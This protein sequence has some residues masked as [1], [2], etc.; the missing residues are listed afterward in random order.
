MPQFHD[1]PEIP[2]DAQTHIAVDTFRMLADPTRLK[3]L[4]LLFQGE[5][6]VS[7]LS[8]RV[9]AAI[10][11][12]SQHLAKLRL[13]GLVTSRREGTYVYYSAGSSHVE[14]LLREALSHADHIT[15]DSAST[16][17]STTTGATAEEAT[18][19]LA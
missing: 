2:S 8:E 3:I 10:P 16:T 14:S 4:W 15:G 9:Q 6:N 19:Q 17:T 13:A 5:A 1:P 18:Q 7:T 11:A 12:V